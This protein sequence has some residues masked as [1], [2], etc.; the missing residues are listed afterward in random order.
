MNYRIYGQRLEGE[1]GDNENWPRH[2]AWASV[3]SFF[4]SFFISLL[5]NLFIEFLGSN[6]PATGCIGERRNGNDK[7]GPRHIVWALH[8]MCSF[9]FVFFLLPKFFIAYLGCN[10]QAT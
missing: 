3:V 9:I 8:G 2:V 10:I 6:L 7:N 5:T 1:A 4:F